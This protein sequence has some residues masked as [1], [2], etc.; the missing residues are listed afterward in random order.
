MSSIQYQKDQDGIVTLTVDMPGQSAN[1][2]NQA[3]RTDFS[4]VASQLESE[5]DGIT[6]VILTSGKKTFFAGGDLNGLL[7]VT[8]EQKEELFK[9]A[10]ELKAAMRRIELLG[11]PVVAA[12]NGSALGGGFELCLACHARFSLAS[13]QI[14]LGL[15]EVNLGLLP[16]G[17]G[18][19]RLVRYLGLEAAMPLLLE[20]TSLS[21]AQALA[22]GLLTSIADD[23][24]GLVKMARDWIKENP[25]AAQPWDKKG[26][27]LP[28]STEQSP[29]SLTFLRTAP[30]ALMKKT[31]G[32]YP[33]PL[34][35]LSAAV[36]GAVVNFDTASLIETRYFVGLATGPVAKNLISTFFFQMNDI[37][38]NKGRPADVPPATFKRVG[39]LG[40]GMMGA[41]IAYASAMR[42]IEAVLKDVSL[43]HAGKGKLHSEK[44]LEKGVSKGKISPSKRDE[45]LQR[46]T[47]TADASGLAGCD[48]IIEAVYEKRELKAEV[49]REA[50]P[51]LAENGLFASNTS[52]LPITGL[53]EAS[54]S[55]ENFIGLHFFSPV[56]RMPLVEIIKGKKTS[57]RTLAHAIDFVKQ[58][59]KTPIVVND[60]RGF[61]TSRVFGTFTKEGAAMLSEGVPAAVIEN[62]A[63]SVG[64]PVGP[65]AVM[66]ETSMALSLSVKR[67]TETDLAS[68]GKSMPQHPGWAVIERMAD[69]LKRPGRAGGGG[70]Y[71]YPKDGQKYLW[72]G[73]VSEFGKSAGD[74][75]L[76]DLRDR[77]LYIQ[78]LE[79]IRILEEGVI[80]TTRDANIGSILGIGFP[81][82]TGGVLQYVNMV[83]TRRF[84][85]RSAELAQRY[86]ERFTPPALLL[87]K[88]ERNERFQ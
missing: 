18:V 84:A 80:D 43:D 61:F 19:V 78:A 86:G 54:A 44:L 48:I 24:A 33:A 17:G 45:V 26:W 63:L 38:A 82:W 60:S 51:H 70:F 4:A 22:K 59:G 79:S 46:I 81:R 36:E 50:E 2:M 40:A 28:G 62:A 27:G 6:G 32:C 47:P 64:M 41:G 83:G 1:T 76:D 72:P 87:E 14:A 5:Q 55:P 12:I 20:G 56:D 85:E 77:I 39:I 42:G 13:P 57:S 52:T 16:G 53:A 21:P 25:E 71:E 15:P 74:V 29:A 65:L 3:F 34:A 9:R 37:K 8:P 11:K 58:I 10:T 69:G 68:E 73:L 67:Q 88:A 31:R 66:D 49:T 7:A 35:I 75:P 30:V 23:A